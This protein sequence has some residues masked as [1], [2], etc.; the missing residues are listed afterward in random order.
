MNMSGECARSQIIQQ[1]KPRIW[2]FTFTDF[3][4]VR[5][6]CHLARQWALGFNSFSIYGAIKCGFSTI[7]CDIEHAQQSGRGSPSPQADP[8]PRGQERCAIKL[9]ITRNPSIIATVKLVA[10]K[11]EPL[12]MIKIGGGREV[13]R[14][15]KAY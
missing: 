4:R 2:W 13:V 10:K 14:C 12:R 9:D 6:R 5:S 15:T 3:I 7:G 8:M 11:K 1:R